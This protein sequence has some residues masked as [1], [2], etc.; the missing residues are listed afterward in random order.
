MGDESLHY[1]ETATNRAVLVL[2]LGL[3]LARF[4]VREPIF[5]TT[6]QVAG[7]FAPVAAMN[8][9]CAVPAILVA[10]NRRG[11]KPASGAVM[12]FVMMGGLAATSVFW[13]ASRFQAAM[14]A[15]NTLAAAC[16]MYAIYGA[17]RRLGDL[18]LV[19]AG[20]A[21]V[22]AALVVQSVLYLAVDRP[23]LVEWWQQNRE[24]EL[25]KMGMAG[26]GGR[27]FLMEGRIASR[28]LAANFTTPNTLA[29][30][31]GMIGVAMMGATSGLCRRGKW[32]VAI[33]GMLVLASGWLLL[34]AGGRAAAGVA[35]LMAALVA[36]HASG[37][38]RERT[39]GHM[40]TLAGVVVIVGAV[41]VVGILPRF[42][43]SMAYRI[44][45]W[46]ASLKVFAHHPWFGVG[47]GNLG[48]FYPEYCPP[49]YPEQVKEPHNFLVRALAELGVAGAV[50]AVAW[51][52]AVLALAWRGLGTKADEEDGE[53]GDMSAGRANARHLLLIGGVALGVGAGVLLYAGQGAMV[54]RLAAEILVALVAGNLML[55][56][57]R[58]VSWDAIR[59]GLAGMVASG[60]LLAMLDVWIIEPA[61]ISLFAVSVGALGASV[62]G[63]AQGERRR[64]AGTRIDPVLAV[65]VAAVLAGSATVVIPA[66]VAAGRA[67]SRMDLA[68]WARASH[69][70][71]FLDRVSYR[72]GQLRGQMAA[73]EQANVLLAECDSASAINARDLEPHLL[74]ASILADIGRTQE[75]IGVY[76]Q[77][78]ELN[79]GDLMLRIR[80][81][82][83]L[84]RQGDRAEG[85]KQIREVLRRND[86]FVNP[87]DRI[88]RKLEQQI[89][90][91]LSAGE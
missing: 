21:M 46:Q 14:A 81:A 45:Y 80:L 51:V 65:M 50:N 15:G 44:G 5:D 83:L 17:V 79:P 38:L 9:F 66:E 57:V 43:Q 28:Q 78:L 55:I 3:M 25:Q 18:R 68:L 49:G 30:V 13:S 12:L 40:R 41:I 32:L 87:Q 63:R 8:L 77:A 20:F 85:L 47:W 67:R 42:D 35:C 48:W 61:A 82:G 56:A 27:A 7:E 73:G 86:L 11:A 58:R 71:G 31:A 26:P 62:M 59:F 60:V 29:A 19:Y 76:R 33:P 1:G 88:G 52:A 10:W 69:C 16:L 91:E 24:A 22:V 74:K 53:F 2:A 90:A 39:L 23:L 54:S 36:L 64:S 70:A 75:S 84:I 34:G 89:R 72:M 6:S 4:L 37:L